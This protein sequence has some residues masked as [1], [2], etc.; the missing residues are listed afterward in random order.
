MKNDT[1]ELKTI[2]NFLHKRAME[3]KSN[4]LEAIVEFINTEPVQQ[5]YETV[6]DSV[7]AP[8]CP[9]YYTYFE[10]DEDIEKLESDPGAVRAK[11]YD[12]VLN[13]V[14][15]GG[16]SLRI[17]DRELQQKM[18]RALGF[19]DEDAAERFDFLLEAFRYGTPPHGGMAYG[20]DRLVMLLSGRDSIRDVIAFPKVQNASELMSGAP[21]V[22]EQKQLDELHIAI[23]PETEEN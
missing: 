13:G 12:I 14:E 6:V 23:V 4:P 19:S 9:E 2:L 21:G 5:I 18:F 3:E 22:V 7:N 8:E 20:L 17:Y 10:T 11:A 15:L 16:G 1:P